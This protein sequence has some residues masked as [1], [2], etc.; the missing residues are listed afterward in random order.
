MESGALVEQM[1]AI[2]WNA[3][4]LDDIAALQHRLDGPFSGNSLEWLQGTRLSNQI[5]DS[6]FIW[7]QI[8]EIDL[9]LS[10]SNSMHSTMDRTICHAK[11]RFRTFSD[12]NWNVTDST[13]VAD[14]TFRLAYFAIHSW[15]HAPARNEALARKK[16]EGKRRDS[17]F[18]VKPFDFECP[19][20]KFLITNMPRLGLGASVRLGAVGSMITAIATGRITLFLNSINSTKIPS[21]LSE[22]LWWAG[23]D[24]LDM[25]CAFL[26]T[27][28]CVVTLEALENSTIAIP[29][30]IVRGVRRAGRI[31]DGNLDAHRYLFMESHLAPVPDR[32]VFFKTRSILFKEAKEMV[33]AL[34]RKTNGT[35][36]DMFEVLDKALQ[37]LKEGSPVTSMRADEYTYNNRYSMIHHAALLYILRLQRGMRERVERQEKK[38]FAESRQFDPARAIGLPIR[39]SDKCIR[40]SVC[41]Q[42]D[43]YINL[44]NEIWIQHFSGH[45]KG[46]AVITTEA[47]DVA[48]ASR[49]YAA[50]HIG[51]GDKFAIV[52]NH[53][54]VLQNTGRPRLPTYHDRADDVME[55]TLV[56]MRLQFQTKFTIGNCCSNFHIMIFDLLQHGC[57]F[58]DT[59][60]CLQ[61]TANASYHVCCQWS[62]ADECNA[63][64]K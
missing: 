46:S 36:A 17:L 8:S 59:Q 58:S 12:T 60:Q 7:S 57:G 54:D 51:T 25:Q 55:S 31:P 22:E 35:P 43:S 1:Q 37:K 42:F 32:G 11:G 63:A 10:N 50:S 49:I 44:A 5:E 6:D 52:M 18:R 15:H 53:D 14:W 48:N 39:G 27:T 13:L 41:L 33:D 2:I 30:K 16:Y 4:T 47:S 62:K 64:I 40:E 21:Q 9:G 23:C 24:R 56:A 28:P 34:R 61:E 45:D 3:T 26:P 20:A 38:I 29:Q 19:N